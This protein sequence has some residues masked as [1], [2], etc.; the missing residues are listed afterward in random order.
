MSSPKKS[1]P[2]L[3]PARNRAARNM[4]PVQG[5]AAERDAAADER[6]AAA[7]LL[8]A[9]PRAAECQRIPRARTLPYE[10]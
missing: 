9:A 5:E 7:F 6:P 10:C 2:V 8:A 4:Q 3:S 1:C